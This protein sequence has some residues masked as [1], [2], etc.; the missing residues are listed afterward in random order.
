MPLVN[1]VMPQGDWRKWE[2][3]PLHFRVGD[4]LGTLVDFTIVAFVIFIVMVKIVGT[5]EPED[6]AGP[7]SARSASRS[8]PKAAKRCRACTSVFTVA[9]ADAAG[10]ARVRAGQPDVHVRQAGRGQGGR[11]AAAAGRVEGGREGRHAAHD[12]QLADDERH[13]GAGGLAPRRAPT[14]SRST[15]RLAYGQSNQPVALLGRPAP[16]D[17]TMITGIER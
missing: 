15:P 12:R 5:I 13:A 17:P 10:G 9:G 11:A 6:A 1:A 16:T 7:R 4:F 8:V 3:T 14:S 2:V